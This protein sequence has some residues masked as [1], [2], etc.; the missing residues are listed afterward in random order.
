MEAFMR[1][2]VWMAATFGPERLLL[3]TITCGELHNGRFVKV[4][5]RKEF[6]RRLHSFM[7]AFTRKFQLGITMRERHK[8][9]ALHAHLV[10]VFERDIRGD[11]DW[12]AC[13]PPKGQDG[14]P[15][16]K[17]VYDTAN[18]ALR[19][20]WEWLLVNAPKYGFGRCESQPVKGDGQAAGRYCAKYMMKDFQNRIPEDKGARRVSYWGHWGKAPPVSRCRYGPNL[21]G[22]GKMTKP[23]W[24]CKFGW[25]TETQGGQLWREMVRQAVEVLNL[26]GNTI[27]EDNIAEVVGPKWAF[28]FGNL[29]PAVVF[30]EDEEG[31]APAL[32]DAIKMHNLQVLARQAAW[33]GATRLP[34]WLHVSELTL[35]DVRHSKKELSGKRRAELERQGE[36]RR[37]LQQRDFWEGGEQNGSMANNK[38]RRSRRVHDRMA[39]T[40]GWER[41]VVVADA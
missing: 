40:D 32:V 39:A 37:L 20:V 8:D 30:R 12:D 24:G 23:P 28:R 10:A 36:W 11:I 13:F 25:N 21:P 16:R 4:K 2:V 33:Y 6:Q 19:E 29:F 17:P 22:A 35:E 27:T 31:M 34:M 9:L 5:D 38:R 7:T 41:P 14:K 18:A 15:V 1:N 26:D 3:I